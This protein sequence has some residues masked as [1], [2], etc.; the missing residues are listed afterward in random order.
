M[1]TPKLMN[2]QEVGQHTWIYASLIIILFDNHYIQ[3]VK[4]SGL[5][6][7]IFRDD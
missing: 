4:P 5:E 6:I 2:N 3:Q 1:K 7:R